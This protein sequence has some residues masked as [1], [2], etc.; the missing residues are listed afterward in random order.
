MPGER[1]PD[2]RE[3]RQGK[4]FIGNFGGHQI[5]NT[6]AYRK[7]ACL[8][9]IA[10]RYFGVPG[11]IPAGDLCVSK[12]R[13]AVGRALECQIRGRGVPRRVIRFIIELNRRIAD[14]YRVKAS[15][16]LL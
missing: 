3:L 14:Q 11:Y 9:A 13:E 16:C 12:Q 2:L 7:S 8:L 4:D 6:G 15:N 10:R 1:H 5:E